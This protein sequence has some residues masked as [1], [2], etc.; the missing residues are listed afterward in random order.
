[1]R[2]AAACH[3]TAVFS[4][5]LARSCTMLVLVESWLMLQMMRAAG[6]VQFAACCSGSSKHD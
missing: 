3:L 2:Q 5:L 6:G 1:V 4:L